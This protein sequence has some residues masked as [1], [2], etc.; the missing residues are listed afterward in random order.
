M[1]VSTK[2]NLAIFSTMLCALGMVVGNVMILRAQFSG[3]NSASDAQALTRLSSDMSNYTQEYVLFK[4]PTSIQNWLNTYDALDHL[5]DKSEQGNRLP[6]DVVEFRQNLRELKPIFDEL[7]ISESAEGMSLEFKTR[8]QQLI[9]ERLIAET[10]VISELGSSWS[11]RINE[12]QAEYLRKLALLEA[13]GLGFFVVLILMLV[14]LLRVGVLNPLTRLKQAADDI[15][16]GKHDTQVEISGGDEIAD[17]ARAVNQMAQDLAN[18][19]QRLREAN[20]KAEFASKAKTDFL[21]SMSHEIRTPLNGIVGLTYLLKDT[22]NSN[23]QRVLLES[24]EK[25]SR[26]LIDLVSDVLDIS[27]IEAGS[28]ELERRPFSMMDFLDKVS[29]L[30]AGAAASKPLELMIDPAPDLP[31]MLLGDELRLRQIV[32][33][34]VGNAIKFTQE[35]YVR[36]SVSATAMDA[37]TLTLRIE[38][39]DS[40]IGMSPEAKSR[41]FREFQQA[42]ATVAR[43]YGGSGLGL[44]LVK[45]LTEMMGGRLGF[46]SKVGMGSHFWVE[47][48]MG[49]V[50]SGLVQPFATMPTVLVVSQNKEQG[51]AICHSLALID[52]Q[53]MQ[54]DTLTELPGALQVLSTQGIASSMVHVLVDF[55]EN[56]GMLDDMK[57]TLFRGALEGTPYALIARSSSTRSL[58]DSVLNDKCSAVLIK[59]VTPLQLREV[60]LQP[61]RLQNAEFAGPDTQ[62]LA[63]RLKVL[64]VDDSELNLKVLH[65]ILTR[66]GMEVVRAR[67]G[68]EAVA[69]LRQANHGFDAVIMD[70]QMPLMDGIAATREIRSQPENIH[71]PVVGLTGEVEPEDEQA[72]LAAGMNAVLPKPLQPDELM[73]TLLRLVPAKGQP[74]NLS[75]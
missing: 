59:P 7:V 72:A 60:L 64:V 22:A 29:S 52:C 18:Q 44:S 37:G 38:V 19:N 61:N 42:D 39:S 65:G 36:L 5:V 54:L 51:T 4:S 68:L 63:P 50:H 32:M 35:G 33:N 6:A 26:N 71:L 48:S 57:S 8:R 75:A 16:A 43:Q 62:S 27:K 23:N 20:V 67:N 46:D 10:H 9:I 1:R 13:M 66:K 12:E 28:M 2:I 47:V 24:L 14:V 70:V 55:Q 53:S 40:G 69:Q 74:S 49:L 41:L 3:I 15:R 11:A 58:L 25:T 56:H 45:S 31:D 21:S 17:V 34:L 73:R 30:M